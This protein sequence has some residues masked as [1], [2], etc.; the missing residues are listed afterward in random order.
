MMTGRTI[1]VEA[2]IKTLEEVADMKINLESEAARKFLAM[3]ITN[4]LKKA[5]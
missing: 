3:K 4:N 5:G 2:I 1:V